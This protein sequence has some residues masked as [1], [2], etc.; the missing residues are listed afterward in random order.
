MILLGK[1]TTYITMDREE[2]ISNETS[3][4]NDGSANCMHFT[5]ANSDQSERRNTI[6]H[7][8]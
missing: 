1:I 2:R 5:Y 6:R 4:E 3:E 7:L 8:W